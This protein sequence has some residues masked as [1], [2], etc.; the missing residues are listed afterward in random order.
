ME[1]DSKENETNEGS[2]RSPSIRISVSEPESH[3]QGIIVNTAT[4]EDAQT[5]FRPTFQPEESYDLPSSLG[6]HADIEDSSSGSASPPDGYIIPETITYT[7]HVSFEGEEVPNTSKDVPIHPNNPSSYAEIATAAEACVE[8]QYG[9]TALAGRSVNFRHGECTITCDERSIR[10]HTQGLC[11]PA[12]WKDICTELINLWKSSRHQKIHLDIYR[13][14]FGLLTRRISDESFADAKRGEI[15][16]LMKSAFDGRRYIPRSDLLRVASKDMIRA[17]IIDDC[18]V[19]TEQK[20]GFIEEV[21]KKA[22]KLLA[23]CVHAQ[24]RM[25]CLGELL[26]NGQ[27][28]ETYPL[29]QRHCCHPKC[30]PNFEILLQYQGGF[31]AAEFFKPGE[32]KKLPRATVVPIHFHP[33]DIDPTVSVDK[34]QETSSEEETRSDDEDATSDKQRAHCGSGAYS[35]VYRVRIDPAHHRLAKVS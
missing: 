17:I 15:W 10:K 26:K 18:T 34:P 2:Q 19:L 8:V 13:E 31:N 5:V 24:L 21:S 14:Y 27:S 16:R 30:G 20:E 25:E 32:H 12:D 28:D 22:P 6:P 4:I 23:M 1:S 7:L 3:Q 29:E 33:K 35:N 11:T 9:P